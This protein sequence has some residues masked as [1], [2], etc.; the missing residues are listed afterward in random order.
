MLSRR[1]MW[2]V[3]LLVAVGLCMPTL[4]A[5]KRAKRPA[6]AKTGK[7][8]KT[9]AGGR[10]RRQMGRIKSGV[11]DGS[12]TKREAGKLVR[13]QRRVGAMRR[14][15]G[16]DGEVTAQE[17]RRINRAQSRASRSIFRQK[18]DKQG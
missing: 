9:V 11:K 4:A 16:A 6:R 2:V 17:K 8:G 18:H 14:K 7:R 10:Q 12:V 3:A 1:M 13:Q 5:G 15:A